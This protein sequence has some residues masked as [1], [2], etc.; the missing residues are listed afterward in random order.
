VTFTVDGKVQTPVP[1]ELTRGS[2]RATFQISTLSA[3][4]HTVTAIYSGDAADSM[5]SLVTPLVQTV[6]DPI[7]SAP[8]VTLVQRFGYHMHPTVLVLTFNTGLDPTSATD[9]NNYVLRDP[10][11]HRIGFK[12]VSYDPLAHTVTL[13]PRE[14]IN[15]HRNYRLKVKGADPHGVSGAGHVLLDGA[16]DGQP[17]TDFVT[18]LNWRQVV[19]PPALALK[20]HEQHERQLDQRS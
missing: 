17:G 9:R 6:M 8:R 13:G 2:E 5:S 16:D 14:L 10:T 20:I 18:T 12:S 19:L 4:K 11:G 15:L 3:G 1:L 7:V